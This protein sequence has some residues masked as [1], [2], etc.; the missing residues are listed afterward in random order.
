[1]REAQ[2][3]TLEGLMVDEL[4]RGHAIEPLTR[5][6]ETIQF[7]LAK[8]VKE[9][10]ESLHEHHSRS[11]IINHEDHARAEDQR[12][13]IIN[14]EACNPDAASATQRRLSNHSA[15]ISSDTASNKQSIEAVEHPADSSDDSSPFDCPGRA[16]SSWGGAVRRYFERAYEYAR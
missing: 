1:M 2:L 7:A 6:A 8:A 4:D 13:R 3:R 15:G 16:P 5:E 10:R 9:L 14:H 12:S 11:R